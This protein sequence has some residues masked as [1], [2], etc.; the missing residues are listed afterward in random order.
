MVPDLEEFAVPENGAHAVS[1]LFSQGRLTVIPRR[2]VRR[3]QLLRHLTETLFRPGRDYREREVN[4]ALR[5]V[6]DDCAALRRYLVEDG[7]LERSADGS[8]YR[9]KR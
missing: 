4:E 5:T 7:W 8:A 2:A 6:H 1:A 3:E 9:R